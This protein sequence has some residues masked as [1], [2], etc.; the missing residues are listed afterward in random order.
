MFNIFFFFKYRDTKEF[1]KRS[2]GL[3]ADG[4]NKF[5]D[6]LELF[7]CDSG[8]IKPDTEDQKKYLEDRKSKIETTSKL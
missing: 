2:P 6:K 7:Y 4:L 1:A 8:E 3:K 5:Q